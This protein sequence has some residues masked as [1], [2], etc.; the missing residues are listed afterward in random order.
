MSDVSASMSKRIEER[1]SSAAAFYAER[2]DRTVRLIGSIDAYALKPIEI[3]VDPVAASDSTVQRIS[4]VACNLTAR[5]SRRAKVILQ[6]DIPL[7]GAV[8]RDGVES[9]AARLLN[10]M[11]SSDPFGEFDIVVNSPAE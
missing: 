3:W 1:W 8:K 7:V 11:R 6:N 5:W 2:D 9:F 10:E 4:L